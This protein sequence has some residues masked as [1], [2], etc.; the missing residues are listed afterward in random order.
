MLNI[1]RIAGG[2]FEGEVAW[3]GDL[4]IARMDAGQG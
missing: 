1:D 3:I 4:G 2:D